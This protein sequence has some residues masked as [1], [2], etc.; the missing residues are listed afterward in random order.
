M[1]TAAGQYE[2]T[3]VLAMLHACMSLSLTRGWRFLPAAA[4]RRRGTPRGRPP[5]SSSSAL[6]APPG[7]PSPGGSSPCR[8]ATGSPGGTP[9]PG[10]GASGSRTCTGASAGSPRRSTCT[11]RTKRSH[12][13]LGR[14]DTTRKRRRNVDKFKSISPDT[15]NIDKSV[16]LTVP[17]LLI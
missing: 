8:T 4:G 1:R 16:S 2:R 17:I 3:R 7:G 9:S 10:P 11:T 5:S 12:S 13:Q 14:A 6:P 15:F